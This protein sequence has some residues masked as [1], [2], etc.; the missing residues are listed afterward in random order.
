MV[1]FASFELRKLSQF[2]WGKGIWWNA[3]F[4][5]NYTLLF[6]ICS[7]IKILP[8]NIDDVEQRNPSQ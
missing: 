4:L 6:E 1:V 2:K 3:N 8:P 5:I 7:C